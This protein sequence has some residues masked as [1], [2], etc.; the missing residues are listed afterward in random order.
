[1]SFCAAF[2]KFY[3]KD[4]AKFLLLNSKCYK[5]FYRKQS[6][7]MHDSW[8]LDLRLNKTDSQLWYKWSEIPLLSDSSE[9]R[10]DL[11]SINFE[12]VYSRFAWSSFF[13]SKNIVQLNQHSTTMIHKW[14]RKIISF[15]IPRQ[16]ISKAHLKQFFLHF[17]KKSKQIGTWLHFFLIATKVR[18]CILPELSCSN[19]KRISSLWPLCPFKKCGWV[20]SVLSP[21][22][23]DTP[24]SWILKT[25]LSQA[26]FRLIL[27]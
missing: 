12:R 23:W 14:M 27:F 13:I 6:Y 10:C 3:V 8:A 7:N 19:Q 9:S 11:A 16:R 2:G 15:C 17:Q 25:A 24:S 21:L 22:W 26:S 1:M 4:N 18:K 5:L 20:Q